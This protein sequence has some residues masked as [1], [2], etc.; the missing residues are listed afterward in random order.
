MAHSRVPKQPQ[1]FGRQTQRRE[2]SPDD[3]F[4]DKA[5]I[6]GSFPVVHFGQRAA[7]D[8]ERPL[9]FRAERW[10]HVREHQIFRAGTFG[11]CTEIK[12][13]ALTKIGVRKKPA[14]LVRAHGRMDRGMDDHVGA[15]G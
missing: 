14:T 13:I 2:I 5:A 9:L 7:G 15:L 6:F 8:L 12:G 11:H 3:G 4:S 1:L 10:D